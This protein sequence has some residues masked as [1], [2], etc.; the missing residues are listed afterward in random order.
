MKYALVLSSDI[1]KRD[2]ICYIIAESI[3][4]IQNLQCFNPNIIKLPKTQY[5]GVINP[6]TIRKQSCVTGN[7]SEFKIVNISNLNLKGNFNLV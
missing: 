3:Q 1:S 7:T 5:P 2:W 4:E 6:T